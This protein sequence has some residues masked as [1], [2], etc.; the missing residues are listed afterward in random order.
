MRD[1]EEIKRV[2]KTDP[3]ASNEL[4]FNLLESGYRAPA[5]Y[6]RI[7]MNY[8]KIGDI[9]SEVDLL[10]QMKRDFGYNLDDRLK[11]ALKHL[12]DDYK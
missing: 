2:S 7:A 5:I 6:E 8:R 1:L 10:L 3:V 11:S 9:K 12:G 4:A